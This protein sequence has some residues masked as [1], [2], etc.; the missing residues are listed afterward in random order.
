MI[1]E[2]PS[3]NEPLRKFSIP[4]TL[5]HVFLFVIANK[6][7][8][9]FWVKMGQNW[10]IYAYYPSSLSKLCRYGH[11]QKTPIFALETVD[12]L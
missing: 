6:M 7:A 5:K 3:L 4:E 8:S 9:E 11:R 1:D 2:F 10:P 12:F